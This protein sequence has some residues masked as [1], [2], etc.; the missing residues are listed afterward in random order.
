MGCPPVPPCSQAK[1]G[2]S[3]RRLIEAAMVDPGPGQQS[4]GSA[5]GRAGS[6]MGRRDLSLVGRGQQ[7]GALA[8]HGDHGKP[9]P[10]ASMP[11]RIRPTGASRRALPR[12][13]PSRTSGRHR[14]AD[15]P[16]SAGPGLGRRR[17]PPSLVPPADSYTRPADPG[18]G[19]IDGR[20]SGRTRSGDQIRRAG[21]RHA[22]RKFTAATMRSGPARSPLIGGRRFR[23]D[24]GPAR[25][26]RP[27]ST[28]GHRRPPRAGSGASRPRVAGLRQSSTCPPAG[29]QMTRRAAARPGPRSGVNIATPMRIDRSE[30]RQAAAMP[31]ATHAVASSN[32]LRCADEGDRT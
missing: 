23:R 14:G 17:G 16:S 5:T 12:R 29:A 2:R 21:S 1:L 9:W 28:R 19:F 27:E 30:R 24:V 26:P 15:Q 20:S 22:I 7:C 4:G 13:A 6:A 31:S 3:P 11:D 18:P 32:E 25:R 8:A 10:P